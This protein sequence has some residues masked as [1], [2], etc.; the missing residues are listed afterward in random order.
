[1]PLTIGDIRVAE[2]NGVYY[3]EF[4]ED[5]ATI[6]FHETTNRWTSFFSYRPENMCTINIEIASFKEGHIY[7]HE[8]DEENYNNFYFKDTPSTPLT[9]ERFPSEI[10]TISNVEPSVVKI[11]QAVSQEASDVWEIPFIETEHG[12]TSNLSIQDFSN[13][14]DFVW[15][16]GHGTK[17]H[18]HYSNLLMDDSSRGGA[19][20]G[21]RLRDTSLVAKLRY[22]TNKLVKL[23]AVNFM[24]S[25]SNRSNE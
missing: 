21:D 9:M 10:T 1:M 17:E 2:I 5:G 8:R 22:T 18:I 14:Q 13:N 19:I 24:I 3:K 6:A 20:E 25:K 7:I 4:V 11:Y 15:Q 16:E 23:F 12:Q